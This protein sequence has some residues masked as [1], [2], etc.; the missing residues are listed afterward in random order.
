[1]GDFG[2]DLAPEAAT[3][4]LETPELL[5]SSEDI[6]VLVTG[7]GPF[8]TN[9]LNPSFLIASCLP[10]TI[11]TSSSLSPVPRNI[12]IHVHPTPIRV[13][14]SAVRIAVPSILESFK[15]A[16][17]GK[18]PDLIVHI[19]MASTRH[20]YSAEAAA[21]RDGYQVTDVDGQ[22]GYEDGELVWKREGLPKV[23]QPGPAATEISC[24]A[25]PST[26]AAATGLSD[27]KFPISVHPFRPDS[28]LL[29]TWRSFAPP[30]ADVRISEDAGRYLCEF[31][32]YASLAYLYKEG[33]VRNAIFFHVPGWTDDASVESGRDILIGLIKALVSCWIDQEPK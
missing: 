20:Y 16:H 22:V 18:L 14:Y 27:S 8:K 25:S 33:I 11:T 5:V 17:H 15:R 2:V 13:S 30:E 32:Y 3:T 29:E 4:S 9:P 23:L 21:H 28:K 7:F 24:I 1:M 6:H 31:I 19:G 10:S 26:P 12:R